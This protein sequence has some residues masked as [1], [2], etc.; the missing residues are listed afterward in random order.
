M[1]VQP[2]LFRGKEPCTFDVDGSPVF[3]GPDTVVRA[4]HPIMAGREDLFE[5]LVVQY[6]VEPAPAPA[7]PSPPPAPASQ[8]AKARTRTGGA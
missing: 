5:P 7:P 8:A 2:D 3:I 4:G 6:D 1:T